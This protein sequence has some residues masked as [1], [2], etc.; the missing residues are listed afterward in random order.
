M[1]AGIPLAVFLAAS[2]A[3]IALAMVAGFVSLL[4]GGA[5]VRE[6]T[7]ALILGPVVGQSQALLAAILARGVF[8]VVEVA[9][10]A[11]VTWVKRPG[12]DALKAAT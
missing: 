5:G 10:A 1:T 9:A 4:P 2:V 6:L 8:L 12:A 11:V 3:A 7:L